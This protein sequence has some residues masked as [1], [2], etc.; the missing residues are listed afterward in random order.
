MVVDGDVPDGPL[1]TTCVSHKASLE[2]L[3]ELS[4]YEVNY[5]KRITA[6]KQNPSGVTPFRLAYHPLY[7]MFIVLCVISFI[8]DTYL[9]VSFLGGFLLSAL[10]CMASVSRHTYRRWS[11]C[12]KIIKWDEVQTLIANNKKD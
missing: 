2:V 4:Q 6:R 5:L 3:M 12:D 1:I 8:Y 9:G 10:F 11:V 7:W